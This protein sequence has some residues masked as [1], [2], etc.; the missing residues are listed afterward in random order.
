MLHIDGEFDGD[1]HSTNTISIGKSGV[2]KC[3]LT[4]QKLIVA[5]KFCG[6][7]DCEAIELLSGGEIEGQLTAASLAI[8]SGGFF[9]GQSIRKK[10]GGNPTVVDFS[11]EAMPRKDNS[12]GEL[13]SSP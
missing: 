3:D 10:P 1:I 8:D 2:V 13:K 9:Q 12:V 5:G 7:A 11:A 6:N 4:A